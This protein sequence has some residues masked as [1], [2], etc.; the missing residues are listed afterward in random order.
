MGPLVRGCDPLTQ[1][2][3]CEGEVHGPAAE[4]DSEKRPG[5]SPARGDAM[6]NHWL[7][8]V[9][10]YGNGVGAARVVPAVRVPP[11]KGVSMEEVDAVD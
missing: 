7:D 11:A 1:P 3:S 5:T 8:D 2:R 4:V 10:K 9:S 6:A